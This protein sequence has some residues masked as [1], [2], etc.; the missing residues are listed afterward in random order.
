[1]TTY[2]QKARE[3]ATNSELDA[4]KIVIHS[5]QLKSDDVNQKDNQ[6]AQ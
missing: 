1:M 6:E 2:S 5:P 4:K 3:N